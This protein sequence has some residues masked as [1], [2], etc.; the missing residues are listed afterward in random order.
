MW[1]WPGLMAP[2][3]RVV[4]MKR[5]PQ[6]LRHAAAG[7]LVSAVVGNERWNLMAYTPIMDV[8]D[9]VYAVR[10]KLELNREVGGGSWSGA[11][12]YVTMLWVRFE[13][14]VSRKVEMHVLHAR[15]AHGLVVRIDLERLGAVGTTWTQMIEDIE[16][17]R[18]R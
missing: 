1:E 11:D 5:L 16:A 6:N 18:T 12:E 15:S 9:N 8:R 3:I 10:I 4:D 14:V 2:Q 13:D 7:L 17:R